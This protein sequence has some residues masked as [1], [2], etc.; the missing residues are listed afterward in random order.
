MSDA[1]EN[2]SSDTL[3]MGMIAGLEQQLAE[4]TAELSDAKDQI[5]SILH[6]TNEGMAVIDLE[7]FIQKVNPQLE[8]MCG[9]SLEELKGKPASVLFIEESENSDLMDLL[10]HLAAPLNVLLER[11][12]DMFEDLCA[13]APV[14][15][16]LVDAEG[17]VRLSNAAMEELTGWSIE[18]LVGGTLE[19]L[20]SESVKDLY[21][22]LIDI[23]VQESITNI[24]GSHSL[25]FTTSGGDK[26]NLEF[27]VVPLKSGEQRFMLLLL[28]G[29]Q[30][31]RR[32]ELFKIST[33]GR[34]IEETEERVRLQYRLL[35]PGQER[36][37]VQLNIALLKQTKARL[38][39][40]SGALLVLH[41]I[42]GQVKQGHKEQ[43]EA[44][45]AGIAEMSATVMHNIG[46]VLTGMH[47]NLGGVAQGIKEMEL[48]VKGIQVLQRGVQQDKLNQE[49]LEL[50]LGALSE[51]IEKICHGER[52]MGRAGGVR[53]RAE[54]LGNAINHVSEIIRM[55]RQDAKAGAQSTR[56]N[57]LQMVHDT[58]DLIE[59]KFNRYHIDLIVEV[60]DDIEMN[61]P[62]NLTMQMLLNMVKNSFEAV[63]QRR[64]D[65]EVLEKPFVRVR[66]VEL[67]GERILLEVQDTGCGIPKE[68]QE[69]IFKY[70]YTT[71]STGSGV[72]LH[73]INNYLNG[74]GGE[75]TIESEGAGTGTTIRAILPQDDQNDDQNIDQRGQ[76]ELS[77]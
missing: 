25:G 59:D 5:S 51:A 22:R 10:T 24:K 43:Y 73:S 75:I 34:L 15:L 69:D 20:I 13:E 64:E 65:G 18:V 42:S 6:S 14:A 56:F 46:N 55:F 32:L 8:R 70:G 11:Q 53:G 68:K 44:F 19:P 67:E 30:K 1:S 28:H 16:L 41:D 61:I 74:I 52:K 62:R 48:L 7:G 3:L 71:K 50:G 72:G 77:G 54:K 57:L 76:P 4:R 35:R 36:L 23:Y 29:A 31:S 12:Y 39:K 27:E 37:P 47:G 33:M 63:Q 17:K 66:S 21:Q 2:E 38:A 9:R 26:R 58:L 49:K 40:S 60:P 45:Q